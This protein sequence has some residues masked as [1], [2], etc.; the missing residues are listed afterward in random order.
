MNKAKVTIYISENEN[1]KY[2]D[3]RLTDYF[4]QSVTVTRTIRNIT[5]VLNCQGHVD[6]WYAT[7]TRRGLPNLEVWCLD[8][9]PTEDSW[10]IHG[11]LKDVSEHY[12][13]F[14]DYQIIPQ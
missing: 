6:A 5:K 2:W 1:I 11:Y 9:E 8:E 7:L 13:G 3:G 4:G 10:S 14:P 12:E